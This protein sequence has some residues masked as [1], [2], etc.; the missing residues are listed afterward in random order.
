MPRLHPAGHQIIPRA[1]GGGFDEGGS[2]D[3]GEMV[4]AEIVAD[5]LHDLAAQHDG[6]MHGGT[7]QIQI[8]VA[9]AQLIVHIDAVPHL[10]GRGLRLAQDAQLAHIQLHIAGGDLIRLGGALPQ[11]A[12][13][14]DHI[15]AAQ[16]LGFGEHLFGGV[17]VKD[18]LQNAGGI[19][20]VGKND[21]ALV[22]A[23]GNGAADCHFLPG[24]R[25]TD[26]AAVVG[27][28]Q[29]SHAFHILCPLLCMTFYYYTAPRRNLQE[30]CIRFLV[31]RIE[32]P[33]GEMRRAAR[34]Q[35]CVAI[36]PKDG[37]SCII[38]LVCDSVMTLERFCN[39]E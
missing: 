13:G 25:Q 19:P 37:F 34:C 36:L 30:R 11:F 2:L 21:A 28:A 9:Q 5:D 23:A 39:A 38:W 4:V 1:L 27:A 24:Q 33:A 6:R 35:N 32:F 29:I 7:A 15:L 22:T 17:L 8:P 20:Q 26:L 18:Q 14:N 10:K 12:F 16:A 3:L 31:N